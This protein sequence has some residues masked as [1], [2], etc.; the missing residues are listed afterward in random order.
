MNYGPLPCPS[1]Y[2]M[3]VT[4]AKRHNAANTPGKFYRFRRY[5]NALE[6]KIIQVHPDL[7]YGWKGYDITRRK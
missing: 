1:H 2:E 3:G 6:R 5:L 7:H 4:V